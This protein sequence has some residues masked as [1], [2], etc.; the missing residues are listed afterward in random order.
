MKLAK[1]LLFLGLASVVKAKSAVDAKSEEDKLA[2]KQEDESYWS[3][4]LDS[5]IKNTPSIPSFIP[6][7][8]PKPNPVVDCD[9]LTDCQWNGFDPD[10]L[11]DGICND[12]EGQC[13]NTA[14]CGFDNGDCLI[15]QRSA[16]QEDILAL[17]PSTLAQGSGDYHGL[18]VFWNGD[19]SKRRVINCNRLTRC[20]WPGIQT[21]WLNDSVCDDNVGCYGEKICNYDEGDC[22]IDQLEMPPDDCDALTT[23]DW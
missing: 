15:F 1:T 23:C 21:S 4:L 6:S 5:D 8:P 20:D 3:R 2:Q 11:G 14:V 16:F 22:N 7:L 12:E 10:K 9:A 17:L 13:Y 18:T 19:G